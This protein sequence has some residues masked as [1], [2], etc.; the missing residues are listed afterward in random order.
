MFI[1]KPREVGFIEKLFRRMDIL[2]YCVHDQFKSNKLLEHTSK[3][4]KRVHEK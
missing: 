1:S 4:V 2:Q 3:P